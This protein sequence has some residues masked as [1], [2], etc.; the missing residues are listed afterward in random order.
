M[1]FITFGRTATVRTALLAG[2]A[3]LALP[4]AAQAQDA[5]TEAD[6]TDV[7][8][9]ATSNVIVV[10]ATKREQTLQETPVAVS[11]TSA[12]TIE[13]AQIRD[14]ADLATVV[15]SLRV[16]Q[17]QSSFATSYSIRGFG[18]DGNNIGLEPSVAM[19]VDGVYRSRAVSQISDLPDIQ[20]VEVLRGPQSTLFGKNASAGVISIVTKEPEFDFGGMVEASYGNFDAIVAKGYVTGPVSD[21]LAFSFGAGI[22]KRDGFLTNGVNGQ[23]IND[24][25]RWFTRGQM[26]FDN[27]GPLRVRVIADYD[28]IEERCCG[29]VNVAP[30]AELGA[31]QLLGGQVNDF[32][33]NPDGDVV[34]TDVDP[35]NEVENY[36]IS[37]QIDYEFGALTL[38]SITAYRNT[39]LMA[40]QDVD[41]TSLPAVT[42][43]NI[44]DADIDTFTQELRIASDFDG[45][46]N[47]LIG[48][49]YF[50]ERVDTSDDIVYGPGFRPFADLLLQGAT[51]GTQNVN[52]LEA[53]LSA[54][55]GQ[56]YTGQFFA[57]GQGF[58]NNIVQDNEAYS[59]FGNVDFE[60]TD[61]LVLTLGANYTKDKKQIVTNS[62]STDVFSNID[63]VA[64]GNTAITQ[65][66]IAVGAGQALNLGR[67]ATA[68]EIQALIGNIGLPAFNQLI[69][70]PAQAFA[71]ANDT[72]PAV[73]PLLA[74]TPFQFLPPLQNCPNAV[75][76]CSTN[77][78]DWSWNV[79]LA[80]EISPTLNV[81]ASWAT[82]YKAPSF[83]LSR[84]SRPLPADFAALQAAGLAVTNL[85]PGTRFANAENSEVYEVGIK[86]NW[87]R[88]AANLTFFQQSIEDFQAN[89]FTGTSFILSN[90]GK[91]ET[92]GVEFDGQFYAS[93]EL[94]LSVAMT[95]LDAKYDSFVASPV[96]DL[97]GEPV[98][99]VPELSAVFGAQ[100]DKEVNSNGDRIILR[101][102]FS[103]ASPVQV[104]DGLTNFIVVD[105]AT[106]A[107]DF[108]PARA[109]AAA[110]KREVNSLNA[111]L[112][113]AFDM[114][115]ELTVWGRNLLDDRFLTTVFPAVAQGQAISGYPNQPR[116]YG[117]AARFRF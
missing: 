100:Y 98:A 17:N 26:L 48:G 86:G 4:A 114:G 21:S 96:G 82:G 33:N 38:T 105:P 106:G 113:Y 63:L 91:Q 51:G 15:P 49:Y 2:T 43:A 5:A 44:G 66:G 103:Y 90:A 111:S 97:S 79:R 46:L 112:T 73:N 116:T 94:T 75:E 110:F 59:F 34:F 58:F 55:N 64:S 1:K 69:A 29:V 19:F 8:A 62:V 89:T 35:L 25:D 12:E 99:G 13:R 39:S 11:V 71:D 109:A 41:F 52:T 117:V 80:Y 3:A 24:R 18:T 92:F 14:V 95:Y 60:I 31:I 87:D 7:E 16:S 23:D 88:A 50:D 53:T 93:D 104:V 32:R 37:G 74:L 84:D 67:P 101:G 83:N 77:D 28:R 20:R 65:Q 10:T 22:N 78:D 61:R 40:D 27:G 30:S 56:N 47:F 115:L 9:P 72:N 85:R 45:P 42:G 6:D 68:A 54:L 57:S 36:G 108:G 70:G 81:Y 107:R 102:D 76:D